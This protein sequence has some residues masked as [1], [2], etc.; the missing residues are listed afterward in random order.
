MF[1]SDV[2]GHGTSVFEDLSTYISSLKRMQYRVSGRG[3][4]GHGAVIEN[5]TAKIT[6]YIKHRQQR[7]DEVVR[8]LRYNHL[9]VADGEASP[10]RKRSWTPLELVKVIYKDVPESLHLPASNGVLLVLKKLEEEG[11]V[12]RDVDGRWVLETGRSAL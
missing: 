3:Y 8:V 10:E 5:A 2:L 4:P 1:F 7:E 9:D 6:E 11:R 12:S